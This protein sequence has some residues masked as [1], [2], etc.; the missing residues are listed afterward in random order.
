MSVEAISP[1]D[2]NDFLS[3]AGPG[4]SF[5]KYLKGQV[6]FAQG[7]PADAVFYIRIGKM[8]VNVTSG[9]G[10][11]AVVAILGSG[12]FFGEGCLSV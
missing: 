11:Q 8:S 10:R 12:D 4:R 9:H 6:V 2:S 7:D 1:L 3:Q 5:S